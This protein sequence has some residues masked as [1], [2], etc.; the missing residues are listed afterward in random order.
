MAIATTSREVRKKTDKGVSFLDQIKN[1]DLNLNFNSKISSKEIM[2]FTNQLA[3][4]IEIGTPLNTSLTAIAGQ[5][6]N[7]VLKEAVTGIAAEVE[8]GKLLSQAMSRYPHV[9]SDVYI[10]LVKSGE[11]TGKLK[12]MLE[13]QTALQEKQ[14]KFVA[15][16][17]KS[18]TYPAILCTLSFAV[19]VFMLVYVFPKFSDIFKEIEDVLPVTTRFLLWLSNF[20]QSFWH[21]SIVVTAL[22]CWAIYA[23]VKSENGKLVFDRLK[24]SVPFLAGIYIKIYLTVTMRMLGFLMGSNIPLLDAL[25]IVRRATGNAVFGR[26]IDSIARNVEEG[27]GMSLAFTE[28]AFIPDTVKQMVKTAEETQNV[29]KV[30]LR[31]S[32]YYEGETDDQLKKFTSMIEPLLLIVMGVVVGGIVLSL[33]LPIFKL[34]R[35]AH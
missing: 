26:F 23:F 16:L 1:I 31:L 9:F 13:R 28:A 10:S 21:A 24:I 35:V 18:L 29:A 15:A 3:L 7:Q 5:L 25:R 17:K 34:S 14:D 8:E 4:M 32:D 20:L 2:F 6:K 19:V 22:C 27:R 12:E 33:I 30:M 11:N